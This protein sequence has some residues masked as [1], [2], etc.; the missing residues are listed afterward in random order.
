VEEILEQQLP[1]LGRAFGTF[2]TIEK[3]LAGR[4]K[5]FRG[6]YVVQACVRWWL[7]RFMRE[8]VVPKRKRLSLLCLEEILWGK[9]S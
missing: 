2:S 1:I 9:F 7:V 8:G 6:P 5:G 4:R 3:A